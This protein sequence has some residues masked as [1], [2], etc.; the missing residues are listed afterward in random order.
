MT[1]SENRPNNGNLGQQPTASCLNA[2]CNVSGAFHVFTIFTINFYTD[3][4]KLVDFVMFWLVQK[5]IRLVA[6]HHGREF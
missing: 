4:R 5:C 6:A 3:F 1:K 2:S